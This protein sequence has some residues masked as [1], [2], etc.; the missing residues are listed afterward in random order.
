MD[1]AIA[2]NDFDA[3]DEC[4]ATAAAGLL[5]G[6][7]AGLNVAAAK[8]V[9][10]ECAGQPPR[11]GGVTIVTLLCDHGIKRRPARFAFTPLPRRVSRAGTSPRSSTTSGSQRMIR[12][13]SNNMKL[14][15]YLLQNTNTFPPVRIMPSLPQN[16][17]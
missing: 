6:G 14:V 8:L 3:F 10:A 5:V 1:R 7:S 11:A 15:A 16:L 17:Y 4:R 2:V 9:A 12:G 13:E